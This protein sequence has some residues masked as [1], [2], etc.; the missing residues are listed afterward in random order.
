MKSGRLSVLL[1]A[2]TRHPCS[3]LPSGLWLGLARVGSEDQAPS[4]VGLPADSGWGTKDC[5]PLPTCHPLL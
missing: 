3:P 2:Q 4:P 5:P 1:T